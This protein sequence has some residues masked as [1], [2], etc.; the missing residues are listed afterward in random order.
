MELYSMAPTKSTYLLLHYNE[1]GT[2][3]KVTVNEVF[4]SIPIAKLLHNPHALELFPIHRH[5]DIPMGSRITR[6]HA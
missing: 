6:R 2:E 4:S 5:R 1:I 3:T